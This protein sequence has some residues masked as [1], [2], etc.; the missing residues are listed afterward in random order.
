M[1]SPYLSR[2]LRS[3]GDVLRA[4]EA[5]IAEPAPAEPPAPK[6]RTR[7]PPRSRRSIFRRR[8]SRRVETTADL[9][10]HVLMR[11][12]DLFNVG[13]KMFLVAPVSAAIVDRV[14]EAM[15]A[16][17]DAEPDVD[18]EPSIASYIFGEGLSDLEGEN[19]PEEISQAHLSGSD[20]ESD[21]Q[22]G[23]ANQ[24]SQ[25]LLHAGLEGDGDCDAEDDD[26]GGDDL[27]HG[28]FD[29][30]DLGE[31]DEPKDDAYAMTERDAR[32]RAEASRRLYGDAPAERR[33][34]MHVTTHPDGTSW[35][36][37]PPLPP[38]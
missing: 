35:L 11:E 17:E 3:L 15:G 28:E 32:Y 13:G 25:L 20:K 36:C 12:A 14:V 4:R 31:P 24:G 22:L 27:D 1:T 23:W 2:P 38:R 9:A 18:D 10:L 33:Q 5:A 16:S 37:G 21:E 6:P 26:P 19:W 7:R 29:P 30:C 8:R 34:G